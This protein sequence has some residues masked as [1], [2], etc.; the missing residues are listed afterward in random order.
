MD[1]QGDLF[2]TSG[3]AYREIAQSG[4]LGEMQREVYLSLIERGPCT[5]REVGEGLRKATSHDITPRMAELYN[6]GCVSKIGTRVCTVT[7]KTVTVWV[8][9][10][11]WPM[12]VNR[13]GHDCWV[14]LGEE[15]GKPIQI[16]LWE[17]D[18]WVKSK[19]S[20]VTTHSAPCQRGHQGESVARE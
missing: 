7:G 12:K 15:S 11:E 20:W 14:L 17:R 2:D 19:F 4:L 13:H 5:A 6:A 10:G 9:N 8:V 1:D 18:G 16:S 3:A